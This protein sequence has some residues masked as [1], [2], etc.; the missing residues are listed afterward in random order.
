MNYR[1]RWKRFLSVLSTWGGSFDIQNKKLELNQLELRMTAP[2]FWNDNEAAQKVVDK[3]TAFKGVLNPYHELQ[4]K[5]EDFQT[6]AE[7]I[8]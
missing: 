4:K 1:N 5:V 3:I 6:L 8:E 2:D 7:L